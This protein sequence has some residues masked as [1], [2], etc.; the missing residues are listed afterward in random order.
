MRGL[1]NLALAL[2]EAGRSAETLAICDQ[3][4][5]ECDD[6]I[7]AAWQRATVYLN[8][9]QW[10][11]A[12]EAARRTVG[13]DAGGSFLAAFALFEVGEHQAALEWFLHGALNYPR[14]ARMLAGD[15]ARRVPTVTSAEEARDHN[16]GVSLLCALHAFLRRQSRGSRRFFRDLVRDARV[17]RL[18]DD[19]VAAVRRWHEQHPTGGREA[20]DQMQR[21]R[22]R[23][24]ATLEAGTLR[25][26]LWATRSGARVAIQ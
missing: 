25:D 6:A 11:R 4:E 19:S 16:T 14:A 1:R 10:T 3:L 18:L 13:L 20:F 2:N 17:A 12:A 24:F 8:T 22:S 21:M 5:E 7:T 23:Q 15:K 26:L 9:S